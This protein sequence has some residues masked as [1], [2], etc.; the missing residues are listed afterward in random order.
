MSTK[1]FK[2]ALKNPPFPCSPAAALLQKNTIIIKTKIP[3]AGHVQLM[4]S[5]FVI[6]EEA[7]Y[8]R[9]S[10]NFYLNV[11]QNVIIKLTGRGTM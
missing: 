1:N 9:F 11:Y 5:N 4:I 2:N 6:F 10:N 3:G 7:V 8:F